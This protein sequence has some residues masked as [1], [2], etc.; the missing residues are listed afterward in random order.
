MK[1]SAAE[2]ARGLGVKQNVRRCLPFDTCKVG[3]LL[4]AKIEGRRAN[5]RVGPDNDRHHAS[6]RVGAAD[7][8]VLGNLG[9][10]ETTGEL[11]RVGE[12]VISLRK[13]CIAFVGD[14][15]CRNT[16][17]SRI[18]DRKSVVMGTSGYVEVDL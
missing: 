17:A 9:V 14:V 11:E 8:Y 16:R 12:R 7:V 5:R 2:A 1:A 15:I 13:S 3:R 6:K 4:R 18:E 10:A